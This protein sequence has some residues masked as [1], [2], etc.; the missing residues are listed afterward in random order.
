MLMRASKWLTV[1]EAA[2]ELRL[3]R[4]TIYRKVHDGSLEAF[5]VGQAGTLR[6]RPAAV[7]A[8]LTPAGPSEET[9]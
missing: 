5:R 9:A 7:N 4:S 6:F 3:S 2:R 8:V 1:D